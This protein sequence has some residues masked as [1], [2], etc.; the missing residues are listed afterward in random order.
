MENLLKAKSDQAIEILRKQETD[1]W[2]IAARESAASP[3]PS[4]DLVV[5]GDVVWTSFFLF[6]STGKKIALVGNFDAPMFEKLEHFDEVR[7]YAK[8]VRD[9]LLAVMNKL[10][11]KKIALNYS[12]DYH[13]ADG[14]KH[15]L[16]IYILR[17]LS[18]T[19][20]EG[21]LVSS[22]N[23]LG[24]L[25]AVKLPE[26][27]NRIK[28]ACNITEKLFGSIKRKIQ[29]GMSGTEIY[30]FLEKKVK[31]RGLEFSFEP[32]ISIGTKSPLGHTIRT[33]DMLDK[34]ELFHIDFGVIYKDYC[35]DIQRVIYLLRDGESEPPEGV[36]IAF[37][38]VSRII[39][40][41]ARQAK[42][43]MSGFA[44]DAIARDM[45]REKGFPEYQH[46]LGHQVGRFVHD[47]GVI[48]GPKWERYGKSPYGHLQ[49]GNVFTLELEIVIKE[50]G[51]VG[52]EEDVVITSKGAKF[53]SKPQ[54]RLV[55]V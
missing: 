25:R 48:L 37:D 23:L 32:S 11:P 30:E 52:L 5:G 39:K 45:L 21:M 43:G 47:G 41:C 49:E 31:A 40:E 44:V 55:C 13:M 8:S 46:A 7:G 14:L 10:K 28:E 6:S 35:S 38:T 24:E 53:L 20:Y 3:D 18:G 1:L 16:Y 51:V 9:D 42:P 2:I 12:T 36:Q 19:P 4:M 17:L 27:L 33:D 22:E 50:V 29:P 54:R 15:G 34:G 26:E